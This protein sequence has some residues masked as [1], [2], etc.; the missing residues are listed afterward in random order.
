M[1][2]TEYKQKL[3]LLLKRIEEE[4][5]IANLIQLNKIGSTEQLV[6]KEYAKGLYD[7]LKKN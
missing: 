1:N 7:E 5:H 6:S 2:E 3:L 4:L